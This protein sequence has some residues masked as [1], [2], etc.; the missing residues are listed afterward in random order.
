VGRTA[1]RL[2]GPRVTGVFAYRSSG[3]L[4][5]A[6][7]TVLDRP[8]LAASLPVAPV[9]L[10]QFNEAL[11]HQAQAFLAQIPGELLPWRRHEDWIAGV[12]SL[13]GTPHA[14]VACHE[15]V[16]WDPAGELQPGDP[17]PDVEDG[18]LLLP[19]PR[20]LSVQARVAR[21]GRLVD[22]GRVTIGSDA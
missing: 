18:W 13:D 12:Q 10:G 22:Q 21:L 9:E 17:L 19:D 1:E 15:W 11:A 2:D 4:P 20:A 16:A 14:I 3:C 7:A 5:A 8:E 6:V